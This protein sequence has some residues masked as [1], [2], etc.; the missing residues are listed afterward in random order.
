LFF[1]IKGEI[2]SGVAWNDKLSPQDVIKLP[3]YEDMIICY[4]TI[5]GRIFDY[6]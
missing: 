4:S 6:D 1:L 3:T 5:Y 2:D